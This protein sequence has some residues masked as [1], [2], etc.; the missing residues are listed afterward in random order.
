MIECREYLDSDLDMVNDILDES[1]NGRKD[2]FNYDN[3]TEFVALKDGV[4]CGYLMLTKI[5]NPIENNFYYLVDYVCVSSKYRG[6]GVGD[7]LMD[8][9]YNYA[10]DMGAMYLQLTCSY[11]RVAAHKL[12][13]RCGYIKRD[14]DIYRK[15]I[16]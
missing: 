14:S 11:N 16:E 12:Y 4:V 3:I 1:F 5:I 10:K 9:V 2:N 7:K 6:L 15:V 13:E 8:Y